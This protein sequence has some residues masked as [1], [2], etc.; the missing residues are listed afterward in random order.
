RRTRA[1]SDT[2]ARPPRSARG[3]SR[4]RRTTRGDL[5]GSLLERSSSGELEVSS[6]CAAPGG[7]APEVGADARRSAGGI[8]AK[9]G[10]DRQGRQGTQE[11][12]FFSWRSWRLG[13]PWR[14]LK[15]RTPAQWQ[16]FAGS[17]VSG[18][19]QP[20]KRLKSSTAL[21]PPNPKEFDITA[22]TFVSRAVCGM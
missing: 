18:R 3:P 8:L 16:A 7:T 22:L 4:T 13:C 15:R 12:L 11:S 19:R 1:S 9:D 20:S 17:P 14:D 6:V 5:R 21:V 2:C 10:Q